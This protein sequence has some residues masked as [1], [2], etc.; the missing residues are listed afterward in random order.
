MKGFKWRTKEQKEEI[1][2]DYISSK[3]T[4]K[5][6]SKKYGITP[7]GI[8]KLLR[9]SG[10]PLNYTHSEISRK[11]TL[12][13]NYFNKVDTED[14][15]YFLGL[16]YA[17]GCTLSNRKIVKITLIE[18]DIEI[19]EKFNS[20][21]HSNRPLAVYQPKNKNSYKNYTLNISSSKIYNDVIKLGCHPQKTFTLKFPTPEQ[22]P[23]HLTHHFVRGY[24]DGDGSIYKDNRNHC[25]E[26][27]FRLCIVSTLDFCI[28]L[29]RIVNEKLLI[30]TRLEIRHKE[31]NH[32]IRQLRIYG[33]IRIKKFLDWIYKDATIFLKRKHDKYLEL[34]DAV[35]KKSERLS[36]KEKMSQV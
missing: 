36:K 1:I 24:F 3:V 20:C 21:I 13:E 33:N 5:E 17:D 16:L 4:G 25:L 2:K 9:R 8:N 7:E 34:N 18:P 11:Y 14:K 15:A 6:L 31:R 22:V 26:E 10:V 23:S 32:C 28:E 30:D 19:L 12:N 27:L 29:T 35:A